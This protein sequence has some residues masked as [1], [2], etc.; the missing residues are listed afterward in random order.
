MIGIEFY[1]CFFVVVV[2]GKH[3]SVCMPALPNLMQ[4]VYTQSVLN[5]EI[6]ALSM[7]QATIY[8]F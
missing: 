4:D 2:V 8:T 7:V 6:L 1:H 3:Y 5:H